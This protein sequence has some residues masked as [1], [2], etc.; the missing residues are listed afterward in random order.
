VEKR[1]EIALLLQS[2]VMI[3][4]QAILLELMVRLRSLD[5]EYSPEHYTLFGTAVLKVATHL[6]LYGKERI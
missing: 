4:A 2:V 5:I 6:T 3:L 1:F